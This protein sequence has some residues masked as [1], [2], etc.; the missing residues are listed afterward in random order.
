M[1][2]G[3]LPLDEAVAAAGGEEVGGREEGV[4][5]DDGIAAAAAAAGEEDEEGT[6]APFPS[7]ASPLFISSTVKLQMDDLVMR[8]ESKQGRRGEE[9]EERGRGYRGS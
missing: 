1:E 6:G 7:I 2:V 9:E 8:G 3:D 5:E 4:D